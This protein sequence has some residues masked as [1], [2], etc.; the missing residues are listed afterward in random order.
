MSPKFARQ[1]MNTIA[2]SYPEQFEEF[3]ESYTK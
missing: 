2:R 3:P 1:S